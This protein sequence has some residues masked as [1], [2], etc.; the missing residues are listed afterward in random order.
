[1]REYRETRRRY[2]AGYSSRKNGTRIS[3]IRLNMEM[4]LF[5]QTHVFPTIWY[6]YHANCKKNENAIFNHVVCNL[7]W[8]YWLRHLWKVILPFFKTFSI[9]RETLV[10]FWT[11]LYISL[12]IFLGRKKN[13]EGRRGKV[14]RQMGGCAMSHPLNFPQFRSAGVSRDR[15][16]MPYLPGCYNKP[17]S[18]SGRVHNRG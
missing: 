3:R 16:D 14:V 2:S 4:R 15:F 13:K 17:P 7:E 5:F 1:M 6:R 18:A 11:S 10:N 12:Y 9:S 8:S